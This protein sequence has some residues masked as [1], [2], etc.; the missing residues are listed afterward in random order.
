MDF[1]AILRALLETAYKIPGQEI[2]SLLDESKPQDEVQASILA[3]D[4]TRIQPFLQKFQEGQNK[5][6]SEALT[7]LETAAK[8]KFGVESDAKGIELIDAIVAAKANVQMGEDAIKV[9]PF[10]LSKEKEWSDALKAK[11]KSFTDL[12]A[13][14]KK[15]KAF[16]TVL[17][18]NIYPE[19]QKAKFVFPEHAGQAALAK[20]AFEDELAGYD[21]ESQATGSPLVM[22]EGRRVDDTHGNPLSLEALVTQVGGKYFVQ[23][24]NNGGG[25]PQNGGNGGAGGSGTST[26]K[27]KTDAE[28]TAYIQD[29]TVP[30]AERDA[31]I[32]EYYA[33]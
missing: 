24:N 6:R 30:I 19:V 32:K 17:S 26:K 28:F 2:D 15:E 13:S 10:F 9:T 25:S 22:K 33:K 20:K 16:S 1:K 5:G 3:K 27:F 31:A 4:A 18:N 11:D 7:Q 14:H 21:Y 12:E 23:A 29:K 8:A